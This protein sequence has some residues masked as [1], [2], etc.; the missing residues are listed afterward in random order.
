[1]GT[2]EAPCSLAGFPSLRR[3]ARLRTDTEAMHCHWKWHAHGIDSGSKKRPIYAAETGLNWVWISHFASRVRSATSWYSILSLFGT[4]KEQGTRYSNGN[5]RVFE[6]PHIET[7]IAHVLTNHDK[8]TSKLT[9]QIPTIECK[10]L[11]SGK[12]LH[13]YGKIHHF[14]WEN[15]LFQ[16]WFSIAILS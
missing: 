15:P 13:N 16:W 1:M 4:S 3:S 11:P 8:L 9:R 6:S 14:Q 5:S 2:S 12:R 10:T 7:K